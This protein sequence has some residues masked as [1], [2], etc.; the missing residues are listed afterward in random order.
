MEI[1]DSSMD[2]GGT[3]IRC[4]IEEGLKTMLFHSS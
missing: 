4:K 2:S 1:G 3:N